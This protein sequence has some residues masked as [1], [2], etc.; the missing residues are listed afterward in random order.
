MRCTIDLARSLRLR[1]VA[2]GAEDEATWAA[3]RA[4]GCHQMQGYVLS[5]PRPRRRA[6]GLARSPREGRHVQVVL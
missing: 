5:R 4:A 6:R 1:V 3:L 2:E